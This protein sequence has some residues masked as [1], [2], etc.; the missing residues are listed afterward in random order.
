MSCLVLVGCAI[1]VGLS[2]SFLR[3]SWLTYTLI[4]LYVGGIMVL[5]IYLCRLS[6]FSKIETNKI[7]LILLSVTL[8]IITRFFLGQTSSWFKFQRG[9]IISSLYFSS[10]FLI[11]LILGIY[12]IIG[13]LISILLI[14]KVKG[15]LK[16]NIYV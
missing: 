13:L 4:L 7:R 3:L 11:F 16:S 2:F 10:R 1:R 9:R 8:I 14:E 6:S 15:P 5:F 12:L